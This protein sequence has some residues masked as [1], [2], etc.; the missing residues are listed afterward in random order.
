MWAVGEAYEAYV[1][2]WS[3]HVAV[4]FLDWLAVPPDRAWLDV[5]CGTGA[6]T[7]TILAET[8]P[9]RIVGVDSS[10]G[11]LD[12]ARQRVPAATFHVADAR[13][14]PLPGND[15]DVVVSG[16]VLNFVPEPRS[17]VAEMARLAKPGALVASYVWDYSE[18]MQ[19]MR[20]FWDAAKAV[21][22]AAE[23]ADEAARFPICRPEGLLA[24]WEGAGLGEVQAD[25]IVVPTVFAD[26]GDYWRPFLGGQGAAPAYLMGLPQEQRSAIEAVLRDRLPTGPQGQIPLHAKAWTIRGTAA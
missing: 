5:G 26:F 14:I 10:E 6:L 15:F 16:L 20:Y 1:G 2:R 21:D 22:P 3:R 25:A 24:L 9:S 8:N 4:A 12:T 18:G 23:Q 11:F 19:L 7:G 17:A 13:E